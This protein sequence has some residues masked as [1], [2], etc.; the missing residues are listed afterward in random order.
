MK[1][2][3]K[4]ISKLLGGLLIL[5]LMLN[6]VPLVG[7]AHA[8]AGA[9]SITGIT[10]HSGSPMGSGAYVQVLQSN[11]ATTSP[12]ASDGSPSGNDAFLSPAITGTINPA[13]TFAG[14]ASVPADQ[15]V[16]IRVWETWDGTGSPAPGTYYGDSTPMDVGGGFGF[17]GGSYSP[18]AFQTDS[19]T[20]VLNITTTK[21]LSF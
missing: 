2:M 21:Y 4:K 14:A 19:Q 11:D 20:A 10:N 3:I 16:F 17:P 7:S 12:P 9:I 18:A 15:Y 1:K 6:S 8:A 5:A 13:G